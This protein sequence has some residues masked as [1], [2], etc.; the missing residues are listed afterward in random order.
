L[1]YPTSSLVGVRLCRKVTFTTMCKIVKKKVVKSSS[2][3]Y[4]YFQRIFP[5]VNVSIQDSVSRN[6]PR[7]YIGKIGFGL[8]RSLTV[9]IEPTETFTYDFNVCV[10]TDQIY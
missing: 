2:N 9:D 3:R 5:R 6:R 1:P 7:L 4:I 8:K 10:V